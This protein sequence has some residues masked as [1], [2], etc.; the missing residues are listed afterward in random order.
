[1]YINGITVMLYVITVAVFPR[2]KII[3][4]PLSHLW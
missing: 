4:I 3:Y 1:M 2:F